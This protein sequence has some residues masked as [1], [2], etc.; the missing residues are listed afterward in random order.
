VHICHNSHSCSPDPQPFHR[1]SCLM[2][3]LLQETLISL[4]INLLIQAYRTH[5][6]IASLLRYSSSFLA[7]TYTYD[8]RDVGRILVSRK[9][10]ELPGFGSNRTGFSLCHNAQTNSR[11]HPVSYPTLT[12]FSEGGSGWG[13][14]ICCR[15]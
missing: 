5:E 8:Q 4:L 10:N 13:N 14:S 12:V 9:R 1:H 3:K 7:V 15:S 6:H 2:K 11:T